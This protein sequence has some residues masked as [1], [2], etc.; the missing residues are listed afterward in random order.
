MQASNSADH[1]S[2]DPALIAGHAAG[3]LSDTDRVHADA[4]ISSCTECAGLRRDLV[5]I[6]AATRSLPAPDMPA[7]DFRLHPEQ[8]DRLRR[9]SWLRAALRPFAARRSAV[10]PMAA[11]FTSLGLAGLLVATVIPSLFGS[12]AGAPGAAREDAYQA[13]QAS[14]GAGA[15]DGA[16]A[17]AAATQGRLGP[18]GAKPSND[19]EIVDTATGGPILVTSGGERSFVPTAAPEVAAEGD[20]ASAT[21][22]RRLSGSGSSPIVAPMVNPLVAGSLGLL[23]LGLLLF[24]LRFAGR[25]LR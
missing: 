11:A 7:R 17:P 10:R 15:T 24:G 25:R 3:D 16:A 19:R 18:L 5:A 14:S 20:Q 12:A 22:V 2:H 13:V 23:I 4:L 8:A 9:G 6:T 21:D 1:V